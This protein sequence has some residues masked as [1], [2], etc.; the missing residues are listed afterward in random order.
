MA[1]C[2]SKRPSRV[3]STPPEKLCI[4]RVKC[5]LAELHASRVHVPRRNIGRIPGL[6]VELKIVSS[7]NAAMATVRRESE[8]FVALRVCRLLSSYRRLLVGCKGTRE[9]IRF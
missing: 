1:F 3:L 6:G 5:L 4:A 8:V 2:T 7:W 9:V